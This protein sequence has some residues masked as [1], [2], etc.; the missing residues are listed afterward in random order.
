MVSV[1]TSAFG[2]TAL[3]KAEYYRRIHDGFAAKIRQQLARHPFLTQIDRPT[4]LAR[5]PIVVGNRGEYL[6]RSCS[7]H[8]E[9][10]V[11][12]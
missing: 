11:C 4:L 10:A 3:I 6:D 7:G 8:D 12:A 9:R 1:A 5:P 2:T